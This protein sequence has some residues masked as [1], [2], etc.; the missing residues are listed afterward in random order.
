MP[1]DKVQFKAHAQNDSVT[2]TENQYVVIDVLAN[3]RGSASTIFSLDQDDPTNEFRFDDLPSG[4]MVQTTGIQPMVV[5]KPGTAF[6]YLA[7]GETATDSFTYTIR[8]ADGSLSTAT[9]E[10]LIVGTNDPAVLSSAFVQMTEG[11]TAEDISTSG[12]LTISDV[13]SPELFVAGT[14]EGVY[15]TFTIDENGNWTY[16]ASSAH[17][18]FQDTN[19]YGEIFFVESVD[20]TSTYVA[21]E[22]MGTGNE[23]E[24]AANPEFAF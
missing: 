9:V 12:T 6:D 7:E 24:M 21:F 11:D 20:G 5:Y 4:A 1:K 2:T 22:I 19:T 18:E 13:D 8:L 3:D 10:V 17:D 16:T 14:Q 23:P 15:G